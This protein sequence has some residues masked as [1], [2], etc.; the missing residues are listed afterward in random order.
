MSD[1]IPKPPP[2]DSI[3]ISSLNPLPF[4]FQLLFFLVLLIGALYLAVLTL[5]S[6]AV[7]IT[8]KSLEDFIGEKI[9]PVAD[10][11]LSREIKPLY[12]TLKPYLDEDLRNL[13]AGVINT[14][15]ENGFAAPGGYI[16]LTKGFLKNAKYNNEKLFVLAHEIGH[17]KNK[18]PL[19]AIYKNFLFEIVYGLL[20]NQNS[21]SKLTLQATKLS[22]SRAQEK[23][24]DLF[25]LNLIFKATGS[26]RG[27]S[28]FFKRMSEEYGFWEGMSSG[29]FSTHPVSKER[30][31]YLN[32]ATKKLLKEKNKAKSNK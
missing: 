14:D 27:A 30:I 31:N 11:N 19:K 4:L 9:A 18:D 16:Y 28:N 13:K 32:E 25:A 8:P 1:F 7:N 29:L 20:G 26:V 12:D 15:Q 24:A 5:P 6:V 10:K 17:I 21:F 23:K 22:F 2:K 3:N